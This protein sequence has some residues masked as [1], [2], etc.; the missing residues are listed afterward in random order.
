MSCSV[1]PCLSGKPSGAV[2]LLPPEHHRVR[3]GRLEHRPADLGR[4]RR[5]PSAI[6]MNLKSASVGWDVLRDAHALTSASKTTT[7]TDAG[8]HSLHQVI[9]SHRQRSWH[10]FA[11]QSPH[12]SPPSTT[13]FKRTIFF[14]VTVILRRELV[15][16]HT[17]RTPLAPVVCAVPRNREP[18]R[19]RRL[20]LVHERPHELPRRVVDLQRHMTRSRRS[21]TGS[22]S[23]D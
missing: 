16:I 10:S 2:E 13:Y 5:R 11:T 18:F 22:S 9:A 3:R 17:A 7:E 14:V 21:S 8:R 15:E 6:S 23:S 1:H 4:V 20:L 19:P 12:M